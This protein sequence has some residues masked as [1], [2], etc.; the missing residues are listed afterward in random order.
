LLVA[1]AIGGGAF[2]LGS[3]IVGGR[4]LWL[5]RRTR[6]VP[7]ALIG[8]SLFLLGGVGYPLHALWQGLDALPGLQVTMSVVHGLLQLVGQSAQVFFAWLVFRRQDAWAAGICAVYSAALVLLF[9]WQ[10]LAPGWSVFVREG[11]G[12]WN[13]LM[14]PILF[15]LGWMTY[16][17]L[18]YYAKLRKRMALGLA[19]PVTTDRLRLW[20]LASLCALLT[21]L[22][23][24]ALKKAGVAMTIEVTGLFVGP[25]GVLSAGLM[26][27]A[28]IPPRRYLDWVL[29]RAGTE[30]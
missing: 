18:A 8:L 24:F 3:L 9:L 2:V 4:L 7:E 19:D 6:Q 22:L 26:W 21:T 20:G 14:Y 30:A 17:P 13:L 25:L 28:F 5:A 15:S 23:S 12:P 29:A 11:T 16:E 27:L 10:T 1:A